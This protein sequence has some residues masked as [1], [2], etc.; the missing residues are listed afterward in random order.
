MLK[1]VFSVALSVGLLADLPGAYGA[2]SEHPAPPRLDARPLEVAPKLDGRV[3]DDPAWQSL[4]PASGFWQVRPDAGRPASQRTEVYV[5]YTKTTLYIGVVCY[6]SNPGA[7]VV[8]DSRRD[9]SLDD[10]DSFQV[11]VDPYRDRQNG[12]VFGT[13]PTSVE[14]DGQVTNE[15]ANRFGGSGRG[16]NLNWDASWSVRSRI[17]Q[18]G[19]STELAIPF[20]SLRYGAQSVQTWGINFQRTIRRNNEVA[21]WA[22]LPRQFN[23][24]RVSEA[25]TLHGLEVPSQRNLQFTPY[26]LGRGVRGGTLRGTDTDG[27]IGFDA[28]Y[29]ITPSLTLDATY[30]TDFAQVE[31]DELQVNLDRFSLFFPEKRPFFLENAGH[32]AVGT[33]EEVELFFSRRIGIDGNGVVQPIDG[34]LRLSG[35]L[36]SATNVGLLHMRT[37]GAAGV[38]ANDYSVARVSRELPNRSSIGALLVERQGERSGDHNHTYAIDGRWGIGEEL[39]IESYVAATE[40]PGMRGDNHALHL[41]GNYSSETWSNQL[42]YTKVGENF[43]PEVGFLR[44][45]NYE[46]GEFLVFRRIRPK[47]WLGMYEIR[48]HVSFRGFWDDEG[49]WESGFLHVDSHWEWRN[50]WEIHTGVNFSHEGVKRPF[51]IN[52]GTFVL[53]GEYDHEEAQLVLESDEAKPLSFSL[54]SI[55]GGFF[56]GHRASNQATLRYRYRD[57]F[58][59]ELTWSRNELDLPFANGEFDVNVGRLR[60]SYSFSPKVLLQALVQYDDRRDLVATNIRFSWLQ[61]ANAGLYLVYNEIDDDTVGG[62]I[63]KRRELVVKFSRILN[64]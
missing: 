23:L 25:G 26:V 7:I 49:F 43:N 50:G 2:S 9:S 37:D 53:P 38:P 44:R 56:G 14:Y 8:A 16:F 47:D 52:P 32:F 24:F 57:A 19:W 59:S 34:G 29:S 40:T 22:P 48:P 27:E 45:R 1:L 41:K 61:S 21:Y 46:K 20:T 10:T 31:V 64:F 28:K 55:F 17:H 13:T 60:L 51:E 35:K 58:S 6:D 15:G 5:G 36:G 30:N 4:T 11:I 18:A 54:Q 3:R 63:D 39:V 12:F 62:P 33:P 42:G